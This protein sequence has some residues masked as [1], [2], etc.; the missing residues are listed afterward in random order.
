MTNKTSTTETFQQ[1][2]LV[3]LGCLTWLAVP[4]AI[5]GIIGLFKVIF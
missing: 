5:L 3:G 4:A 2:T 1:F